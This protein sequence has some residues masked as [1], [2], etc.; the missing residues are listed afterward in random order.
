VKGSKVA[1]V[2]A[3]HDWGLRHQ[4]SEPSTTRAARPGVDDPHRPGWLVAHG[5]L[6]NRHLPD[7]DGLNVERSSLVC[8]L[9][10]RPR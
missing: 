10:V 8:A 1:V 6:T 9:L 5:T 4:R 2:R 3:A 7:Q